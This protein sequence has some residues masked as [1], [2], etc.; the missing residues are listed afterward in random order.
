MIVDAPN[1]IYKLKYNI[2]V[3]LSILI[4][5]VCFVLKRQKEP[6][7]GSLAAAKCSSPD[8]AG[9]ATPPGPKPWPFLGS[10]HLFANRKIP[11]EAFT[12]L[13]EV[14]FF[15]TISRLLKFLST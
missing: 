1:Y 8:L 2:A 7:S 14:M 10:L 5:L 15:F 9:L 11:F 3:L 13:R 12:S 6:G 4:F